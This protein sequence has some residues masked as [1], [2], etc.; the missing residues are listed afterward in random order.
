MNFYVIGLFIWIQVAE[1]FLRQKQTDLGQNVTINCDLDVKEVYWILLSL[2]DP[3]VMIL[4]SFSSPFYYNEQFR[5][6]YSVQSRH[7]LLISNI[8]HKELGVYYCV[9]TATT[10]KKFSNGTRLYINGK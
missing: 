6:K 9:N 3:P 4:R 8:T 7:N 5:H 2:P 1:T 10:R